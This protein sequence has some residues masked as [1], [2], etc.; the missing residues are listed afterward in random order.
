MDMVR[1]L[2]ER[3]FAV[4]LDVLDESALDSLRAALQQAVG[5]E[6]ASGKATSYALRNLLA[7]VP[8]V[9]A[10]AASESLRRLVEPI[11]GCACFAVRGLY[12]D[13]LPQSNWKVPWHQ[14][15]CV[16]VRARKDVEGFGPWTE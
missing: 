9:R 4:V 10:L 16:A 1:S 3:G 7:T 6:A 2:E 12:F 14:D 8:A 13:K 15:L 5:K 11:L